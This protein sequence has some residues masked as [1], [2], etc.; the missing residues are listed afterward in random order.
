[1]SRPPFS[2]AANRWHLI[3]RGDMNRMQTTGDLFSSAFTRDPRTELA[4]GAVLLHGFGLSG[5]AELTKAYEAVVAGLASASNVSLVTD[6]LLKVTIFKLDRCG[7]APPVDQE[8][9]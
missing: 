1:M 3:L 6:A 5:E 8:L 7:W 2:I 9:S 4:S